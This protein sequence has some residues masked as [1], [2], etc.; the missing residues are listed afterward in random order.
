MNLVIAALSQPSDEQQLSSDLA[1]DKGQQFVNVGLEW[2]KFVR[3][4]RV[5]ARGIAGRLGALGVPRGGNDPVN[6]R[7]SETGT[8]G[9][10]ICSPPPELSYLGTVRI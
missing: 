4:I 6:L 1:R 10:G 7:A 5:V 8:V 3:V 2:R 9:E